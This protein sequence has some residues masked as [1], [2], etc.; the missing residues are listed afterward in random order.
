MKPD[1]L[2]QVFVS[3]RA[4]RIELLTVRVDPAEGRSRATLLAPTTDATEALAWLGRH[5]AREG[6]VRSLTRL[7]VRVQRGAEWQDAPELRDAL[8]RAFVAAA[9]PAVRA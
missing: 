3:R 7:R 8:R 1:A 2:E 4:G 9:H 6:Q 5:L